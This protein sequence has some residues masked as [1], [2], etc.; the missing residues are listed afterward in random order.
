[1][2]AKRSMTRRSFPLLLSFIIVVSSCIDKQSYQQDKI[3]A[4]ETAR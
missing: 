4:D 1:L 3:T 2:T